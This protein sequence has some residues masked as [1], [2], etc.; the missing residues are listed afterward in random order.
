MGRLFVQAESLQR[1]LCG[2]A[3]LVPLTQLV[4]DGQHQLHIG[5][6]AFGVAAGTRLGYQALRQD[7]ICG[8]DGDDELLVHEMD[9][10][11]VREVRNTWQFFRDRR[12][13]T[14]DVLLDLN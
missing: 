10:D 1:L 14:Y 6:D 11:M 3:V 12:P 7:V 2:N 8:G 9:M 5:Q 4:I 13:E